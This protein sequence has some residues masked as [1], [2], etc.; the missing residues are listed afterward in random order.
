M[1]RACVRVC[2]WERERDGGLV[3]ARVAPPGEL[4]GGL[5][6]WRAFYSAAQSR[7]ERGSRAWR[8]HTG[9]PEESSLGRALHFLQGNPPNRQLFTVMLVCLHVLTHMSCVDTIWQANRTMAGQEWVI[10]DFTGFSAPHMETWDCQ[11]KNVL[12]EI[13]NKCS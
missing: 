12:N 4:S 8:K 1:L 7:E 6:L 3:V 11:D 9:W 13:K 5:E 2:V 10:M